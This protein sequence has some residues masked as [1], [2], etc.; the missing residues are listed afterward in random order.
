VLHR[1]PVM[2]EGSTNSKFCSARHLLNP[3]Q[4]RLTTDVL[5]IDLEHG[6]KLKEQSPLESAGTPLYQA[7][8]TINLAPLVPGITSVMPGMPDLI[9]EAMQRYQ[10]VY[11]ERLNQ[12]TPDKSRYLFRETQEGQKEK[13]YHALRH[14]VE[15]VFW[16]SLVWAVE[17]GPDNGETVTEISRVLW[18]TL[19]STED[20]RTIIIKATDPGDKKWL[21]PAYEQLEGL[22]REMASHLTADLHWVSTDQGHPEQMKDSSYLREVFQRCILNFLFENKG[23]SF[24][25]Q[26]RHQE[27][28][29]VERD[30]AM[31]SG[32]SNQ[33]VDARQSQRASGVKRA[34]AEEVGDDGSVKKRNKRTSSSGSGSEYEPGK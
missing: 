13:W 23:Q 14:D 31:T 29:R 18:S 9:P 26:K 21:D 3:D 5:L 25:S 34:R 10:A 32:L 16:I 24:M 33:Q 7:R 20:R 12:F 28:R 6:T 19:A 1:D 8:A 17:M 27:N 4:H 30:I 15:S 22:L 11:P 2:K